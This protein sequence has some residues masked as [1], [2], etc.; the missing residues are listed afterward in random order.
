MPRAAVARPARGLRANRTLRAI[1]LAYAAVWILSAIAPRYP[2]DWLLEN[3]LVFAFVGILAATYGR[4][5]FSNLSYGLIAAF[6]ALHSYGAHYTYSEA[7]LGFWMAERFGWSR[8]HYD[9]VVHFAYGLLLT[10]PLREL[11][12]RVLRLRGP[13]TYAIPFAVALSLSAGYEMVESWVARIVSP[14]LGTAYLGTQ[15]D[16][17]DAQKDMD[18]AMLGSATCLALAFLR[19]RLRR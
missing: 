18:Q 12:Q 19:E 3:L 14:E 17:W 15:G 4:F 13:W 11:G 7:P 6:L 16:E 2:S 5:R 9:R 1:A 8:N 10:W